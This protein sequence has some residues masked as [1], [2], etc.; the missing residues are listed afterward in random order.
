MSLGLEA[1]GFDP[2]ALIELN[3]DA[4]A[5]LRAN[6]RDWNVIKQDMKQVDYAPHRD[7]IHL[8]AGGLPCQPYSRA[9]KALGKDDERDL[10]PAATEIVNAVRPKAFMFEN[11]DGFN[12]A[13]HADHRAEVFAR[14][15]EAGYAVRTISVNAKDYGIAQERPRIF[16]IGMSPENM[17]RFRPPPTF[18]EW[19]ATVGHA[20]EDMM[21]AGGWSGAS[22][23]AERRRTQVIVRDNK[24]EIGGLASTLLGEKRRGREK[25]IGRW[26]LREIIIGG[27]W[28]APPTD[29]MA[30][31]AGDDFM[32][33]L[34]MPMKARLMGLP[35]GYVVI[36]N[37]ESQ[38]QQ[39]GNAVVPRVAQAVGL[40]IYSALLGVDFDWEVVLRHPRLPYERE[41]VD[42][43]EI[44]APSLAYDGR[45]LERHAPFR[46]R[47]SDVRKSTIDQALRRTSS[48]LLLETAHRTEN[49]W[50]V[51]R[52]RDQRVGGA[53]GI[54]P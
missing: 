3:S 54:C 28:D 30:A 12:D 39:I 49:P 13:K 6:R 23:W 20:L 33:G 42:R 31:A 8:L 1:A 52:P 24:E 27:T 38:S 32:P 16:V 46:L 35:D 11:V 53:A 10:F 18:E 15:A 21:G 48:R 9:G 5:S 40:A 37:K 26:G 44:D 41:T 2:V 22:R 25:E 34:T 51:R 7:R 14:F 36:G 17:A 45:C 29:A 19:R 43:I 47:F 50:S 4:A